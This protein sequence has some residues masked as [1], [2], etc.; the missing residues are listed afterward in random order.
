MNGQSEWVN[1]WARTL[2][3][4]RELH[5]WDLGRG[6]SRRDDGISSGEFNRSF[7]FAH[8]VR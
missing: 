4:I 5:D 1:G 2:L 8:V 6:K 3:P 7:N